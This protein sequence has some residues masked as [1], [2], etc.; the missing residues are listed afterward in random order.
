VQST[1]IVAIVIDFFVIL[2]QLHHVISWCYF[3]C[4]KGK[5]RYSC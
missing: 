2:C 3:Y 4:C 5:G 1:K